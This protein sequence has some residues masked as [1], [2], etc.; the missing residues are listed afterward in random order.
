M[1]FLA[2]W[3]LIYYENEYS[4]SNHV[5]INVITEYELVIKY[6]LLMIKKNINWRGDR[7][8]EIEKRVKLL[9]TELQD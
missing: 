5:T 7:D 1:Q 2:N 3:R 4:N 8:P 9:K 6:F